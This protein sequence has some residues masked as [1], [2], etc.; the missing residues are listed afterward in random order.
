MVVK[1]VR[2]L[3]RNPSQECCKSPLA[4]AR[5]DIEGEHVGRI[6]E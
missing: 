4:R 3:L 5:G 6:K 1:V 2:T